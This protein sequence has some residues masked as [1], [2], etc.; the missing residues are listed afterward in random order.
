MLRPDIISRLLGYYFNTPKY[1]ADLIRSTAEFFDKPDF[2]RNQDVSGVHE[3]IG[4][5]NE[6]FMYDFLLSSNETPLTNFARTNPFSLSKEEVRVYEDLL[7]NYFGL[8]EVLDVM[9]TKG[10][11]LK[12]LLDKKEFLVEEFNASFDAEKGFGIFT[13]VA[14]VG[15]HYE[16]VGSNSFAVPIYDQEFQP[17][18]E[19]ILKKKNLTPKDIHIMLTTGDIRL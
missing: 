12:L 15:N 16:M 19:R 4:F 17:Y 6:W 3:S 2:K 1:E 5:Y 7:D 13:R 8:F 9:P 11:L 10:M 14:R 18:L